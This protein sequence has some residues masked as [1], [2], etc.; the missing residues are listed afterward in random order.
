MKTRQRVQEEEEAPKARKYFKPDI[1]AVRKKMSQIQ[2]RR[3]KQ[4]KPTVGKNLIRILPPWS[5]SGQWFKEAMSHYVP[6]GQGKKKLIGC[7]TLAGD[8]CAICERRAKFHESNSLAKQK[9]AEA[10]TPAIS[11][12]VNMID[13]KDPEKGVQTARLS[14]KT[15]SD[16]LEYFIDSEWGDFTSPK[17]GHNLILVREGEGMQTRYSI[18]PQRNPSPIED[19]TL[20]DS[21]VDLDKQYPTPNY[22]ETR[23]LLKELD[24]DD[25]DDEEDEED[26]EEEAPRRGLKK[27]RVVEDDEDDEPVVKKKKRRVVD[28]EDDE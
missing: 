7:P 9:Q 26:E 12:H 23:A 17:R 5:K 15:I 28:D 4:W 1:E 8:R 18:K 27:R 24:A 10:L 2:S 3:S 11:F 20:L 14:E 16:L 6:D 19:M 13:L 21:I 22:G 25:E